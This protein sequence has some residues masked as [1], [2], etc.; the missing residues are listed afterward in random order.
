L[1]NS[2]DKVYCDE[3]YVQ[4]RWD[5]AGE[6]VVAEWRSWAN[7]VEFRAACEHALQA[8]RENRASKWLMDGR[9]LKVII[10]QDQRWLAEDWG[11]RMVGAGVRHSAL[12]MPKSGLAS[13]TVENVGAT[14]R[15]EAEQRQSFATLEEAKT[16]LSKS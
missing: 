6:W 7:S 3:P 10:E 14:H 4:V 16:W 9:A 2:R 5:S 15:L 1:S 11:P 8:V 13:L 12:V